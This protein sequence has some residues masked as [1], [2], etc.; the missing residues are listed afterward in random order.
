MEKD[1]AL[2]CYMENDQDKP[3]YWRVEPVLEFKQPPAQSPAVCLATGSTVD[4]AGGEGLFLSNMAMDSMLDAQHDHVLLPRKHYEA[5]RGLLKESLAFMQWYNQ[6]IIF[7]S[8][9]SGVNI[10]I[11][12]LKDHLG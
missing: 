10:T 6:E 2:S 12:R 8:D 9:R 3:K 7:N 11:S 4:I 5:M 1:F